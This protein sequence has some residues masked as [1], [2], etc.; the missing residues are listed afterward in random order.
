MVFQLRHGLYDIQRPSGG[1]GGNDVCTAQGGGSRRKR[2]AAMCRTQ[3]L[4]TAAS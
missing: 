3:H 2:A 1:W 4:T